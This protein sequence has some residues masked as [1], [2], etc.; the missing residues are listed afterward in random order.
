MNDP[1]PRQAQC[2]DWLLDDFDFDL[3]PERIASQPL[4]AREQARLL[5]V[6]NGFLSD[7]HIFDLPDLLRSG[8]LL[9]MNDTRVIPARLYGQRGTVKVETLLHKRLAPGKWLSLAKPGKR[10][11]V[12]D[13]VLYGPDFQ[14][15]VT[16]KTETGDV[17]LDFHRSDSDL[18]A[19]LARYGHVPLPPYIKRP[20]GDTEEDKANYQTIYARHEGAVA[21][22]T[23][24]LHFTKNLLDQLTLQSIDHVTLTLHVGAGTFLPVKE[25]RVRDHH[26]HAEW[27]EISPETADII[28]Q[29]KKQGRRI[30][31]VGT[32]SLRLLETVAD[33]D[34]GFVR[35]FTGETSIFIYPG[36]RFK[37]VDALMTNFHLPKSTLFMLVSALAGLETMQAA[38]AHAIA[39]GYRFFSYGDAC[40]LEKNELRLHP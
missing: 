16:G 28:N 38:Y 22:P 7:K 19:Q 39:N 30:V 1:S 9:V 36:Y 6:G 33:P 40:L 25:A 20:N 5:H 23:A 31:S 10:L 26:M 14:A 15:E 35:P 37:I 12:G 24:G 34:T 8:D 29:A 3:P 21:A 11:H 27:G 32:T 18:F 2:R 17:E 4:A 13:T